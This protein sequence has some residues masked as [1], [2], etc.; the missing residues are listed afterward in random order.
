MPTQ[1]DFYSTTYPDADERRERRERL[2]EQYRGRIWL[3][4][5]YQIIPMRYLKDSH[6]V[7]IFNRLDRLIMAEAAPYKHSD[8]YDFHWAD[9]GLL[10]TLFGRSNNQCL[11]IEEMKRRGFAVRNE[12]EIKL[13]GDLT[14]GILYPNYDRDD[15]MMW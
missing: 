12:A 14:D 13:I 9:S 5:D 3:T 6:L 15:D 11:I 4:Q 8:G 7:N 10:H 2:S 1:N